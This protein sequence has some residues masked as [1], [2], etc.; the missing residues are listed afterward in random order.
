MFD[1]RARYIAWVLGALPFMSAASA[2][3]A[4]TNAAKRAP[5]ATAD[6]ELLEYLGSVDAEGQEWMDYL[7]RTDIS[8]VA[9]AKKPTD[10]TE[11]E[12]K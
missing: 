1:R 12:E 5:E 7:A 4:N 11:V 6:A 10:T 8:Q 9:K 2:D 3:D